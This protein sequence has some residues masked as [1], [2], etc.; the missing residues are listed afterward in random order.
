MTQYFRCFRCPTLL[1]C[2]ALLYLVGV[3]FSPIL[4]FDFVYLDVRREV[5]DNPY[6]RDLSGEN[7]KHIFTSR[8]VTSYY[9]VRTLTY[10]TDH[11]LWGLNPQGFKLTGGLLH[12]TNVLLLFGLFLRL[13]Q[14]PAG[15]PVSTDKWWDVSVATLAAGV[16]AVHPVVVQPVVW[17]AGRE[18]LLMTLGVLGCFHC[19]LTARRLG[20]MGERAGSV[21]AWHV[22]ATCCCLAASLSSA[23]A[24]VTPLLITTWDLVTLARPKLRRILFGTSAMWVIGAVTIVIKTLG[25]PG[26]PDPG[27]PA[28]L[29][30]ERLKL[31]LNGYRL[32]LK[33][34]F[35]PK[36]L[37]LS[38][39]WRIPESL[40]DVE[41]IL[42]VAAIALTGIVLWKLRR[43]TLI[44]FGLLWFGLALGPTSQIMPH[45]VSRADRFLYLP[46]VGLALAVAMGLRPLASARKHRTAVAAAMLVGVAGLL[47]LGVLSAQ[48][49]QTWRDGVHVWEHSVK[50]EPDNQYSHCRLADNLVHAGQFERAFEEYKTALRLDPHNVDALS[51]FAWVLAT[52]DDR[53]LRDYNLAVELAD[54]ACEYSQRKDQKALHQAAIVH[55]AVAGDLLGRGQYERAILHYRTAIDTDPDYDLPLFNLATVLSNCPDVKLRDAG[56]AVLLAERAWKLTK[57]RSDVRRLEILA[58]VYAGA[59]RFDQAAAMIT[60][61]IS[62]AEAAGDTKMTDDLRNRLK[63]LRKGLTGGS[64]GPRGSR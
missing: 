39:V 17:V 29:S 59:G 40:L 61:A 48:Q 63:L 6:I 53:R 12:L 1:G 45:H 43:R 5:I 24:A 13:A 33:T 41:V 7:L 51:N 55:C 27:A 19:H 31:V 22:A 23:V 57:D 42:A 52:C 26:P 35:W 34:L 30:I 44:L 14:H 49:V 15:K 3:V 60:Q 8:C 16:F 28:F 4:G 10:A 54:L 56:T 32:N 11:H 64:Q 18:E 46:L 62:I 37:A 50:V 20:E 25:P 47:V 9:P 38:Y 2:L 21:V 58:G 36:D